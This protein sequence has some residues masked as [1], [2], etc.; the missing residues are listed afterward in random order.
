[1]TKLGHYGVEK[2]HTTTQLL[3]RHLFVCFQDYMPSIWS[4]P[5]NTTSFIL[6]YCLFES[7]AHR[8]SIRDLSQSIR[9][10]VAVVFYL[11]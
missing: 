4:H 8:Q 1:M 3:Q 10:P 2:Y 9:D 7:K 6:V 11:N 5:Q